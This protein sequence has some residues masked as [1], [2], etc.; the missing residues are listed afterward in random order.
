[1]NIV[2][3]TFDR[4]IPR[5][6]GSLEFHGDLGLWVDAADDALIEIASLVL[7]EVAVI[8]D[9]LALFISAE[10][11]R[12]RGGSI[13]WLRGP[14]QHAVVFYCG[15]EFL[16]GMTDE[17]KFRDADGIGVLTGLRDANILAFNSQLRLV[18]VL[19]ELCA[20]GPRDAHAKDFAGGGLLCQSLDSETEQHYLLLALHRGNHLGIRGFDWGAI[21]IARLAHDIHTQTGA[22]ERKKH[23]DGNK[24]GAELAVR[25]ELKAGTA[26]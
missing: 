24:R 9:V 1:M 6:F 5:R 25:H 19:H 18:G 4:V 12:H 8:V 21:H 22:D 26:R 14:T 2:H 23:Y 3:S 16:V 20:I 7:Q 15:L 17:D 10:D 11:I 13:E